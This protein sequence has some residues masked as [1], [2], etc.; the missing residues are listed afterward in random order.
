MDGDL[1]R[2]LWYAL[3]YLPSLLTDQGW[4]W[5]VFVLLSITFLYFLPWVVAAARHHHNVMA[6][7]VLNV[8]LGWTLLGWV[9]ALVWA[10]TNPRPAGR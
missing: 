3:W 4:G 7:A 10:Y 1:W 6:I 9:I 2:D 5:G 8:L